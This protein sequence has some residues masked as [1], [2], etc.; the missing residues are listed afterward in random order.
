MTYEVWIL[1]YDDD[2]MVNDFEQ[3]V[4]TFEEEDK[5]RWFATHY[6]FEVPAITPNAKVVVESVEDSSC[7]DLILESEI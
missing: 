2:D 1:G 3:L 4:G 7:I 6:P 5:A